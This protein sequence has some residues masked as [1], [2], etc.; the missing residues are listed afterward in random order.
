VDNTSKAQAIKSFDCIKS[1]KDSSSIIYSLK[2]K[3]DSIGD[4]EIRLELV[5][6]ELE[7]K[8][9]IKTDKIISI[10]SFVDKKYLTYRYRVKVKVKN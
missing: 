7:R 6:A 2:V 10:E 5:K 9:Q 8:Y 3:F 4:K 1:Q